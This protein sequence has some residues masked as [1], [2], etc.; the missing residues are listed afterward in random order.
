MTREVC[1]VTLFE[2][3]C[4]NKP[5]INN[6]RNF[7]CVAWGH[8]SNDCRIKLDAK[9]HGCIMMGYFEEFKADQLIDLVK[10][11]IIIR[12]SVIFNNKLLGVKLLNFS[13]GMLYSYPLD[14]VEEI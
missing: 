3:W 14:I 2:K 12:R 8:I 1:Y 9:S 6:L 13:Y 5:S 7:L 10:Q 4:G 11:Y